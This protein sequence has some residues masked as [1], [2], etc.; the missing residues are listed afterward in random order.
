LTAYVHNILVEQRSTSACVDLSVEIAIPLETQGIAVLLLVVHPIPTQCG[1]TETDHLRV[2]LDYGY[3]GR[4]ADAEF[5]FP[6]SHIKAVE[7][8]VTFVLIVISIM[9]RIV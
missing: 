2:R 4:M 9:F 6:H 7:R 1:L 3:F 8:S 5:Q